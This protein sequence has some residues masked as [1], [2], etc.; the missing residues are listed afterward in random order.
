MAIYWL[1]CVI[2]GY[3]EQT[4]IKLKFILSLMI[5]IISLEIKPGMSNSPEQLTYFPFQG[6]VQAPVLVPAPMSE[7][8]K[9]CRDLRLPTDCEKALEDQGIDTFSTLATVSVPELQSIGI[10]LGHAKRLKQ[11]AP[12]PEPEPVSAGAAG[13]DHA[14]KL[15]DV[16]QVII[17]Y[18]EKMEGKTVAMCNW[19]KIYRC[20]AQKDDLS[21]FTPEY[22][23]TEFGGVRDFVK[24][25]SKGKLIFENGTQGSPGTNKVCLPGYEAAAAGG[26]RDRDRDRDRDSGRDDRSCDYDHGGRG[27]RGGR[28]ACKGKP[29]GIPQT[30]RGPPMCNF[31]DKCT[32]AGCTYRHTTAK[33]K[34]KP[35]KKESIHGSS[36]QPRR[37][38]GGGGGIANEIVKLKKMHDDGTLTD[39]EF[40]LA[41]KKLIGN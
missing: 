40:S 29:P 28:G 33:S 25:Y 8:T 5:S 1:L 38:G 30:G 23:K 7:M 12:E 37:T 34:P 13:G 39:A 14:G 17:N 36:G 19:S 41:K 11:G 22:L 26:G 9:L 3:F 2:L 6:P 31:D 27:G 32:R 16:F 20:V 21:F 15:D 4:P 10:K 35:K 24:K 18:L